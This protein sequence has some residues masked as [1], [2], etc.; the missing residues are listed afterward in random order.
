M[1]N[2]IIYNLYITTNTLYTLTFSFKNF[3]INMTLL[4]PLVIHYYYKINN[5]KNYLNGFILQV[6]LNKNLIINISTTHINYL[7]L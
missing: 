5:I 4:N 6:K 7:V 3:N 1:K 2:H